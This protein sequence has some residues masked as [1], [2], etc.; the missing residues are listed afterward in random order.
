MKAQILKVAQDLE[1]GTIDSDKARSLLL[2][3]FGVSGSLQPLTVNRV[4]EMMQQ[5]SKETWIALQ[6]D[7]HGWSEWWNERNKLNVNSNDR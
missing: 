1:K 7:E 3:L 4:S 6:G 2:G 5:L